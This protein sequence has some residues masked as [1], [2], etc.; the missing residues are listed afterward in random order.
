MSA[1]PGIDAR[2]GRDAVRRLGS[3]EPGARAS[4]RGRHFQELKSTTTLDPSPALD[5]WSVI[6]FVVCFD[7]GKHCELI[8][9]GYPQFQQLFRSRGIIPTI[10]VMFATVEQVVP[11]GLQ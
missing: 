8:Q 5:K 2:Q 7:R 3:R 4:P 6:A 11:N 9:H 1:A 10:R